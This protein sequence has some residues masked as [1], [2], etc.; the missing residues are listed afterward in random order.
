MSRVEYPTTASVRGPI[1][2]DASD[3]DELDE[4]LEKNWLELEKVQQAEI[5]REAAQRKASRSYLSDTEIGDVIA[6]VAA[7]Y[8][9]D[10][11]TRDVTIDFR[12]GLSLTAETFAQVG[13]DPQAESEKPTGFKA[14]LTRGR[15]TA[16]ITASESYDLMISVSSGE[17]PIQETKTELCAWARSRQLPARIRFWSKIASDRPLVWMGASFV[18]VA[19]FFGGLSIGQED[20]RAEYQES[21]RAEAAELLSDGAISNDEQE[22]AVAISLALATDYSPSPTS[23]KSVSFELWSTIAAAVIVVLAFLLS[24][25]RRFALAVGVGTRQVSRW[26]TWYRFAGYTLPVVLLIQILLPLALSR[27]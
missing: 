10:E 14:T 12:S 9:Y 6:Q 7:E 1:L 27:L 15:N 11:A 16:T 8:P 2:L 13:R 22:R 26:R 25:R 20:F 3:L 23:G 19:L 4:I 5:V 21:L 18:A 17:G 24:I